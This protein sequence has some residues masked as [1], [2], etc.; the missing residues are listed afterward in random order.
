M[1]A[2]W[3]H[4]SRQVY[5]ETVLSDKSMHNEA[6]FIKVTWGK[7]KQCLVVDTDISSQTKGWTG[8]HRMRNSGPLWETEGCS[9]EG[10]PGVPLSWKPFT[11][12]ALNHSSLFYYY[13]SRFSHL[14]CGIFIQIKY[15]IIKRRDLMKWYMKSSWQRTQ[16]IQIMPA[17]I[18]RAHSGIGHGT[19]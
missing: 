6:I 12:Q 10:C 4:T 5:L 2:P 18:A 14:L 3:A 15:C 8:W 9:G 16:L 1:S 13:A 19:K 7:T 17:R 11:S